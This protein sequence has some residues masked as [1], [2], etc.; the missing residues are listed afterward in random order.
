MPNSYK[1]LKDS[2][3]LFKKAFDTNEIKQMVRTRRMAEN[4]FAPPPP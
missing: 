3:Y 2:A 1:W 4:G